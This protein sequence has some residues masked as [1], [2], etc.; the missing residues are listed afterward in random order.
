LCKLPSSSYIS[1][2]EEEEWREAWEEY[3]GEYNN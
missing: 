3:I 2:A 1:A